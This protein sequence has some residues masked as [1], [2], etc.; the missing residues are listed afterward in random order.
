M[1]LTK[2]NKR[3]LRL[4]LLSLLSLSLLTPILLLVPGVSQARTCDGFYSPGFKLTQGKLNPS[5]PALSKPKKGVRVQEPSFKTCLFR[6]TDHRTEPSS[7]YLRNDYSRRQA[8]NANNTYFLT[9]S[10]DG[11]WRLYDANSLKQLRVLTPLAGDAEPQWHPTDPNTLYYVPIN[12]GTKLMKVDVRNN[13]TSTAVDFRGKLPSWAS[14]AA[15]IWTRS[16]GSP[17]ANGRY[18]GF[19]VYDNSWNM[20]GH[21]VW[22]LQQQRLVG[23]RKTSV[24]ADNGSISASGRWFI[25]SG[26]DGVW[27]WSAN[28]SQKKKI[29]AYGG[30]HSDLALS[31]TGKDYFVSADYE[32]DG[33]D[34][35]FVNLDSCPSVAASA[36][37]APECPRTVLFSMYP[38]GAWATMHFSGKAFSKPGW[39]LISTYDTQTNRGTSPWFKDKIFAM[40]LKAS[41]KV[42][43]LAFTHRVAP[44]DELGQ[45]GADAYWTE[46][47]ATVNRDFTRISFNSNWGNRAG[48]D[49]DAYMI[50]LPSNALGATPTRVPSTGGNLPPELEDAGNGTSASAAVPLSATPVS[51]S[52]PGTISIGCV[53]CARLGQARTTMASFSDY[54]W[55]QAKP[56]LRS[57]A[58]AFDF[59]SDDSDPAPAL[60]SADAAVAVRKVE[61]AT[62]ST[63]VTQPETTKDTSAP[64]Q[65]TRTAT[66]VADACNS[67]AGR[68]SR[69]GTSASDKC[70]GRNSKAL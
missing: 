11:S 8:F 16:E 44:N 34:V 48:A 46:P 51:T 31:A 40:E 38:T 36:T 50:E 63:A 62:R 56:L 37:S 4:S 15:H 1:I 52:S 55:H 33:G 65:T 45:S 29:D 22:D 35:Y 6:A 19:L 61:P 26:S 54:L 68:D 57:A 5:M 9:Y 12:G 49:V 59:A 70:N 58:H 24:A 67:T 7:I 25:T 21:I 23:S 64:A 18:W 47:H 41:P 30:V 13:K 27:A 14:T 10:N 20:L 39:V 43:E 32:S 69:T 53:L 3:S 28:F 60:R 17:S 42:Y 2:S 66:T